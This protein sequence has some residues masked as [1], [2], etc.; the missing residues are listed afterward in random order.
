MFASPTP[1]SYSPAEFAAQHGKHPSW[2]YRR[3][4]SGAVKVLKDNPRLAI[5]QAEVD[6][7]DSETIRYERSKK[8]KRGKTDEIRRNHCASKN[9][10]HKPN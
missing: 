5:P 1:K 4:Y 8:T 6:R 7:F 3:V 2:G 9:R 10:K